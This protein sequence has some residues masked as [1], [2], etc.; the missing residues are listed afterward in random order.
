MQRQ[1]K[2]AAVTAEAFV[3]KQGGKDEADTAT[4]Q[5]LCLTHEDERLRW[6]V[7]FA[8]QDGKVGEYFRVAVGDKSRKSSTFD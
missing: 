3:N 1:L 7:C 2:R 8:I 6:S 5:V 4:A